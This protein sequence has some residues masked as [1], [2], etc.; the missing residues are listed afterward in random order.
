LKA[1]LGVTAAWYDPA[2]EIVRSSR[3]SV[4]PELF[5][6]SVQPEVGLEHEGL[7]HSSAAQEKRYSLAVA[8]VSAAEDHGLAELRDSLYAAASSGAEGLSPATSATAATTYVLPPLN[9]SVMLLAP[10]AV[11]LA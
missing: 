5:C 11:L 6:V 4:A 8:V 1:L 3:H 9:F 2:A 7:F 10:P